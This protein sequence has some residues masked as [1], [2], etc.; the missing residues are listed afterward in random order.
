MSDR[1][2]MFG[3]L[4]DIVARKSIKRETEIAS[5]VDNTF[6]S[7]LLRMKDTL[8]ESQLKEHVFTIT[9]AG[10]ETTG[11]ASAHCVLLLA[12]HP[13]IQTKAFEEIVKIFPSEE[14]EITLES[15]SKLDYLDRVMK[16]SLRLAPTVHALAREATEDFEISPGK[17]IPKGSI[18]VIN[19]YGLH[20]RV[21]LWGEDALNFNPD[22]FLPENF[23]DKQQLFIPFSA[24]KRNC[25]GYRYALVS[26]KIMM[27][28]LLRKF[29]FSTNLK[30][31]E[32]QFNRQI[33]LKLVG[34]HS[35][36]VQ[37]RRHV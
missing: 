15:L 9:G 17:I 31:H 19:I 24:G 8:T 33:A 14:S 23:V 18:F 37:K 25:I 12:L 1:D 11:T 16:E 7:R 29:E 22:R 34:E 10:Y 35:V 6:L 26:F 5:F 32:I 21:D 3:V 13:E 30:A 20:R 4:M 36:S 2:F 27:V 28:K